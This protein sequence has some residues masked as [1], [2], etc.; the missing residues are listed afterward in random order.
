ML[1]E[2]ICNSQWFIH[3][4]IILFLNK[5]DLFKEKLPTSPVRKYF[6]DYVGDPNS[7]KQASQY[8]EENFKRLNRNAT[9]VCTFIVC[10]TLTWRLQDCL[11]RWTLQ[12]VYVH[13][14]NA[15]DTNLLKITMSSVQDMI[16]QKNLQVLVL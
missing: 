15:T 4:S 1:F 11:D 8:F 12:D 3:T 6:P 2:S 7:Y 10:P 13:F 5:T 14:T 9:K 16:L